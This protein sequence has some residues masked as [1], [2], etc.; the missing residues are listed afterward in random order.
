MFAEA[1]RS[2]GIKGAGKV[3]RAC[4][5]LLSTTLSCTLQLCERWCP[6]HWPGDTGWERFV[7]LLLA[8]GAHARDAAG[9]CWVNMCCSAGWALPGM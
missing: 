3:Q 5:C 6:K 2:T 7:C 8:A 1:L 9:F 4:A